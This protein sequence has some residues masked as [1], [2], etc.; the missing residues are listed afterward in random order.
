MKKYFLNVLFLLFAL[1]LSGCKNLIND[2]SAGVN[3]DG[4]RSVT[5]FINSQ[6][7]RAIAYPDISD[8][9]VA[10][11]VIKG[12]GGSAGEKEYTLIPSTS[13]Y[14]LSFKPS[15]WTFEVIAYKT[16]N[17]DGTYSDPVAY[18]KK[19]N[20]SITSSTTT[21]PF[22]LELITKEYTSGEL[23]GENFKGSV[24]FSLTFPSVR[25]EDYSI[26]YTCDK[27][28]SS[29]CF[30]KNVT[31][32]TTATNTLILDEDNLKP[33]KH[34]VIF[35]IKG[36]SN[37]GLI[38]VATYYI[39]V[40]MTTK[41]SL[42]LSG[43]TLN[44][45]YCAELADIGLYEDGSDVNLVSYSGTE[46]TMNCNGV[47]PEKSYNLILT[48]KAPSQN[49]SLKI[50]KAGESEF[51]TSDTPDPSAAFIDV[52]YTKLCTGFDLQVCCRKI[53]K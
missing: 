52:T 35:S 32:Q 36:S 13:G 26:A 51:T 43:E 17:S 50:K 53:N 47:S 12:N 14:N 8:L 30:E 11:Y 9:T 39:A 16:Y 4:E 45:D 1:I 20:V 31:L 28:E 24:K 15:T 27:N 25:T 46:T 23:Q 44:P 29:S 21:L 18:V 40:N 38:Y 34:T 41:V 10:A 2:S 7:S 49:I 5:V 42:D 37:I 48:M 33:G 6:N 22:N 19:D 3:S